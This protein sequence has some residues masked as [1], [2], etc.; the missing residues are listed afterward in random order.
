MVRFTELHRS[1][2]S[3]TIKDNYAC[4]C[5]FEIKSTVNKWGSSVIMSHRGCLQFGITIEAGGSQFN[6]QITPTHLSCAKYTFEIELK[7]ICVCVYIHIY[8]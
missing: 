3:I 6:I 4:E 8:I 5:I 7:Y 1:I 2:T